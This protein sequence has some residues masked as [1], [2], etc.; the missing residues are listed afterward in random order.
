MSGS[1]LFSPEDLL[2]RIGLAAGDVPHVIEAA[3]H[4]RER[5]DAARDALAERPAG[6]GV[7]FALGS[8]GRHEACDA[9]DLDLAW[10]FDARIVDGRAAS[11]ERAA[12]VDAL[13]ALGFVVPEKTF[14]TPV[15]VGSLV[16]NV[17]GAHD[18]NLNLTHRALVL[19]EGTWLASPAL[20]EGLRARLFAVYRDGTTRGRF[21]TSLLNDL[22]RYYRTVCVDYRFKVE[23]ADKGWALRNVK[24]RHSRKTWH[25]ANLALHCAA[26]ALDD[27]GRHDA[28]LAERL[29]LP[30][31]MKVA[32]AMDELG[33]PEAAR[34]CADLWRRYDVYLGRVSLPDV[35]SALEVLRP[36]DE[37]RSAP[38]LELK[39]N[40]DALEIAAERIVEV[41]LGTEPAR[42]HLLR[43][44]L[45]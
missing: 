6:A 19:T 40:A 32:V 16:A 31:L 2:P 8:L 15:D 4:S 24:L 10:L 41:L 27:H 9:S 25:L 11:E 28:F 35:R 22:H 43:F 23:E 13:R 17:G 33:G 20:A 21:M 34:E 44:G 36:E 42:G 1:G 7:P 30:P 14:S 37:E 5:I 38:Y 18:T 29:Q 39:E 3:R 45:L 12:C 26:R